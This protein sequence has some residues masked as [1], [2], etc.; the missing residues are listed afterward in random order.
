MY[1]FQWSKDFERYEFT[2]GKEVYYGLNYDLSSE[3]V[4]LIIA[5]LPAWREEQIAKEE[6]AKDKDI[7][8]TTFF[9]CILNCSQYEQLKPKKC[10][11]PGEEGY[12]H[13]ATYHIE[14]EPVPPYQVQ[15]FPPLAYPFFIPVEPP[16]TAPK[17]CR[18]GDLNDD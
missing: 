8:N 18:R 11:Y 1:V 17:P 7:I 10:I 3:T 2:S 14:D 15:K 13:I 4:E 16:K 6:E 5:N 12:H 9:S